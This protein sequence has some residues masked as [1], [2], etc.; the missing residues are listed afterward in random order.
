MSWGLALALLWPAALLSAQ[1]ADREALRELAGT[2]L[3]E[4]RLWQALSYA[5]RAGDDAQAGEIRLALGDLAGA[6]ADLGRALKLAPGDGGLLLLQARA[7][8]ERPAEALPYARKAAAHLLVGEL[9]VDLGDAVGAE[10]SFKRALDSAD[11]DLDAH[12][13]MVR[14]KRGR[15]KEAF[16]YAERAE[17]AAAKAPLWRRSAA[18]R[19]SARIWI[20]LEEHPR[21]A[22]N[23]MRALRAEPDDYDALLTLVQLKE[24]LPQKTIDWTPSA[25][26]VSQ[27][28]SAQD[29]ELEA[30]RKL[31]EGLRAQGRF[32][33]AAAQA[34]RLSRTVWRAPLWQ[35][36][37]AHR[38]SAELWL[39]LGRSTQAFQSLSRALE[40]NPDSIAARRML[41]GLRRPGDEDGAF[42]ASD[43]DGFSSRYFRVAELRLELGDRAGAKESLKRALELNADNAAASRLLTRLEGAA[44]DGLDELGRLFEDSLSGSAYWQALAYA[45]RIAA[46]PRASVSRRADAFRAAG[47]LRLQLGDYPGAARDLERATGA[48]PSSSDL[49]HLAEAKREQPDEALPF[50]DRAAAAAG[51]TLWQR[52]KPT[53]SPPSSGSTWGRRRRGEEALPRPER[54][55][56]TLTPCP[57]W[58]ASSAG[59][60]RRRCPTPSEP[61]ARPPRPRFGG[62]R[63]HCCGW[64]PPLARA[65][66]ARRPSSCSGWRWGSTPRI[67]T[68]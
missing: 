2:A 47:E 13:A 25:E 29:D 67:W 50:A 48:V 1:P 57:R 65:L 26:G 32:P 61:A 55:S 3:D 33:E 56:R 46:D 10:A 58:S 66:G 51:A 15:K 64:A 49:F 39:S 54:R 27:G 19:L 4:G 43:I 44:S 68:L 35:Q 36:E 24:R 18:Q 34:Q 53:F 8:R 30:L 5:V 14:L 42:A 38:L 6:E 37:A 41:L 7:K 28:D 62:G 22:K 11:G 20:E 16:V 60:N 52:A 45:D 59:T 40:S 9:Q 12:H 17:R 21:A 23:L 31:S 63:L